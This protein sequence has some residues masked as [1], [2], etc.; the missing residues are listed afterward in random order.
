MRA[1]SFSNLTL[2]LEQHSPWMHRIDLRPNDVLPV[3]NRPHNAFDI[4]N[5]DTVTL[6]NVDVVWEQGIRDTCG[7]V[8]KSEKSEVTI[9]EL[10][11]SP[12]ESVEASPSNR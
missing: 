10:T 1:V 2:T 12:L 4:V 8:V 11:V 7:A 9:S 5:S 6:T 3:V